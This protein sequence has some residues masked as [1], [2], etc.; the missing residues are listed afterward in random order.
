MPRSPREVL[1]AYHQ[2]MIDMSADDLA[3]LYAV[4]GL[5]VF[6]FAAPGFPAAFRGREEV[7]AGYHRVWDQ[8]TLDLSKVTEVV[9]YDSADPD[10]VIGEWVGAGV[11][12]PGREPFQAR[13]VLI[14]T[15]KNGEITEMRD[16]MDSLGTLSSLGRLNELIAS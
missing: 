2:A 6:P 15:V 16:Y 13:G 9:T 8:L 5:H 12:L 1:A 3:D 10:T 14:A 4:D 11:R 7:R